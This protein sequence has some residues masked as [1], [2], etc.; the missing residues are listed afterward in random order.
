RSLRSDPETAP[1]QGVFPRGTIE[2]RIPP[3]REGRP[4]P[5]NERLSWM[6]E[7]LPY[8]GPEQQALYPFFDR[9]KS[10]H[11]EDNLPAA[12]VLVPQF[13][14]PS[15]P[16]TSWWAKAPGGETVAGTHF[17]GIAGI[18][19]DAAEY[20]DGEPT[21]ANKLGIFGYDRSMRLTDITDKTSNTILLAQVP[22]TY[23][24]AWMAGGGSNVVGVPETGS[25][26]P[27]IGSTRDGKRGTNVVMADGSVRF[28]SENV[29]DDVF[30]AL[31][32]AKGGEPVFINRDAPLVP[33][34]EGQPEL[35]VVQP[36]VL[37]APPRPPKPVETVKESKTE[38]SDDKV[39]AI[40]KTHCARCH[41]AP[42]AKGPRT[43]SPFVL[44]TSPGKLNP[45][46]EKARL[47][48]V[49]EN[50]TMPPNDRM[51]PNRPRP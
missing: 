40:F 11:D 37:T 12:S 51:N 33:L 41:T 17:V 21:V 9:E 42:T 14:D 5:P 44:F 36:Q 48:E 2:R 23:K 18:G 34:P 27:F 8:L 19:L 20:S 16:Q 29:S 22:P 43:G 15:Y 28:I 10:W 13:L 31:C 7:L 3:T 39:V 35:K 47:L 46:V 24:R 45:N 49:L 32:T 1:H 4:Y 25:I 6:V 30:K 50:G 26:R 38:E